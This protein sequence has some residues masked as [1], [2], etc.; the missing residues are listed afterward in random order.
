ML[1]C[2][3][4]C[5]VEAAKSGKEDLAPC[6]VQFIWDRC[7]RSP[8]PGMALTMG[9]RGREQGLWFLIP[10][11]QGSVGG[12]DGDEHGAVAFFCWRVETQDS[13]SWPI[14]K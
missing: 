4:W 5:L 13:S 3:F 1:S 12:K 7:L 6:W 11:P 8:V 14:I 9:V 2:S 10:A